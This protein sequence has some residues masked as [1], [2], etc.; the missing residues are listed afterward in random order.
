MIKGKALMIQVSTDGST[1]NTIAMATSC[2]VNLTSNT[3]DTKTK[4][5]NE[6]FEYNEVVSQDWTLTTENLIPVDGNGIDLTE[7]MGYMTNGTTLY[8]AFSY[9]AGSLGEETTTGTWTGVATA[10]QLMTG[11]AILNSLTVNAPN[12]ENASYTAE[13]AG[14]GALTVEYDPN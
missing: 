8:V 3:A 7:L 1:Y 4:D 11:T 13:F 9:L 2:T 14:K 6:Q 10:S 12:R 5:D